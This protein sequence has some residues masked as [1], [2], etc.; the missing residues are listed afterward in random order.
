[1]FPDAM[2]FDQRLQ[3]AADAGTKAYSFWGFAGRPL[4]KMQAIQE[5]YG[6]RCASITGANKTGWGTGLTRTGHEKEFLDDF[7]EAVAVAR[8]LGTENL[9]T[10]VGVTQPDIP[11]ETQYAQIVAGLKKAGDIAGE[12]GVCLT[13]EPLNGVESPQMAMI[14]SGRAF[15]IVRDVAHP[16]VKVDFDLYHR[17]LGEGNLVNT[18]KEGLTKGYVRFVEVGDV[19]GRFEPGTGEANY[20]KL[21]RTLR[22]LGYSGYIGLEHRTTTTPK[23]AYEAVKALA[24][25]A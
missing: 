23:G 8:R 22:E 3:I 2:P 24:G 6:L 20:V 15:G 12:A 4:D 5:K 18:L 1:M 17:Q 13:L 9:I 25:L 11:W 19:P 14:T 16:H 21:F 10:F 7:S